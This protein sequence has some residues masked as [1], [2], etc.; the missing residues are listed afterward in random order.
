MSG[1]AEVD[2]GLGGALVGS[3]LQGDH[4]LAGTQLF[5]AEVSHVLVG[6]LGSDRWLVEVRGLKNKFFYINI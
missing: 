2:A 3:V 4:V 6:L 5:L 1:V